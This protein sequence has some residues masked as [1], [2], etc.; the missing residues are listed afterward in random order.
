MTLPFE[1][2]NAVRRTEDFLLALL[3]PKRTPRVPREIRRLAASLLKHYP[4]STELERA[5]KKAPE[6]FGARLTVKDWR[7][8]D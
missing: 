2:S 5:A 3:D 7:V 4:T 8:K 6:I 1:R